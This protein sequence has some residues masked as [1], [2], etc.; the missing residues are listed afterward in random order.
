MFASITQ[1]SQ[2]LEK[3]KGS[4][5]KRIFSLEEW[6]LSLKSYSLSLSHFPQ[7]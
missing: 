4:W 1:S 2:I 6:N 7:N 3:E 5:K